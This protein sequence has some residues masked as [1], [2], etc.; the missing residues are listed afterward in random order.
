VRATAFIELWAEIVQRGIVFGRGEN[1]INFVSVNE[2][3]AAVEHAIIEPRLRGRLLEIGGSENLTLNQLAARLNHAR[4]RPAR[5][6][7]VPLAALRMIGPFSRRA[8]AAMVMDTTDMTF[9]PGVL[10]PPARDR[11]SSPVGTARC[12]KGPPPSMASETI[13]ARSTDGLPA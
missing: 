13:S 10:N 2:V 12:P 3:A 8:R 6:L 4:G 5:V 11:H 7:H 9:E 1:P